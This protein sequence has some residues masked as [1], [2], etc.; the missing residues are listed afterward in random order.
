LAF[1]PLEIT[2]YNHNIDGIS[3]SSQ[4]TRKKI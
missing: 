2:N 4:S 3:L 1:P